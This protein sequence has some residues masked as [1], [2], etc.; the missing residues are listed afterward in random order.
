MDANARMGRM[1]ERRCM[2]EEY[3]VLGIYGRDTLHGNGDRLL[4]FT[5]NHGLALLKNGFS[6][7][8]GKQFCIRSGARQNK[9]TTFS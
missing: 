5:N 2:S 4:S 6:A 7:P 9:M 3:K 1:G 8:P